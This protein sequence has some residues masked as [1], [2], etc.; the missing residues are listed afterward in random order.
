MK[1][2]LLTIKKSIKKAQEDF[3]RYKTIS[4]ETYKIR[5]DNYKARANEI[6][7]TIPVLEA[8][9]SGKKSE[10]RKKPKKTRGILEIKR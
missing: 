4:A 10:K 7:H 2:E 5:A 6:K 9:A 3:L 1:L 8:I